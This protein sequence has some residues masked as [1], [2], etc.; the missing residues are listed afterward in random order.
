M[1]KFLA[2]LVVLMSGLLFAQT[3]QEKDPWELLRFLEGRWAGQGEGMS[4]HSELTQDYHFILNGQFLQM[5]TRAVFKPQEKNPKGEIHEDMGLFSYDRARKKFIMRG[6]YVE[7]FVNRYVLGRVSEDGK[8]FIFET[9]D[10][11]NGPPGTKAK[12]EFK[13]MGAGELEQ[14][15]YVA[16]PGSEY[17]C[18]SVN[19]LKKQRK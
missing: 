3:G 11:E 15:F 12:L 1:K 7:G 13:R 4:G 5:K 17:S 18:F 8:T 9:E 19:K 10:V 2:V 6:F 14:S 16:F